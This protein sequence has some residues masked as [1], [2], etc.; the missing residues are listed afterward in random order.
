MGRGM[1]RIAGLEPVFSGF[2][3][4]LIVAVLCGC[5]PLIKQHNYMF[6]KAFVA[7]KCNH[8]KNFLCDFVRGL[9]PVRVLCGRE[10]PQNSVRN[11]CALFTP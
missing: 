9:K 2:S 11:L 8:A 10:K 6:F 4:L 3:L 1:V 7:K 5:L